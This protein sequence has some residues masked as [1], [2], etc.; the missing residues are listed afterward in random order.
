MARLRRWAPWLT[1]W[2]GIMLLDPSCVFAQSDPFQSNPGPAAPKPR[3]QPRYRPAGPAPPEPAP[4]PAPPPPAMAAAEGVYAGAGRLSDT[5]GG[6]HCEASTS[7]TLRIV[8]SRVI[9]AETR[10]DGRNV[11]YSGSIDPTGTISASHVNPEGFVVTLAGRVA[12]GRVTGQ[13]RHRHCAFALDLT[14]G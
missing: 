2:G 9:A 12:N 3:P 10:A 13:I 5:G 4:L 14:K 8:A 6:R 7:V 1:L 11:S